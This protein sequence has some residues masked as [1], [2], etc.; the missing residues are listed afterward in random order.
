MVEPHILALYFSR[1][2]AL[3]MTPEEWAEMRRRN[4]TPDYCAGICA[5]HDFCDA[6]MPMAEA[7]EGLMGREIDTQSDADVALWN[8]AWSIAKREYLTE[9]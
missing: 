1:K 9:A 7:F 8:E 4:A 5:S 3:S 6:N 2:L